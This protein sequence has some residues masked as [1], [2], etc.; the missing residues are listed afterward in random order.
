MI[1]LSR[2]VFRIGVQE[3]WF[4]KDSGKY[5]ATLKNRTYKSK[6]ELT[7]QQA[8]RRLRGPE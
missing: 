7:K 3:V 1:R 4:D 2:K 5:F 8:E 6:V